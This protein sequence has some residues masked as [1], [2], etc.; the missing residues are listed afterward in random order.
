MLARGHHVFASFS[1]LI[2]INQPKKTNLPLII[3]EI[4]KKSI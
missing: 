1:I 4:I 2:L 3:L